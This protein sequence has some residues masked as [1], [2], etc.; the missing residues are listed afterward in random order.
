MNEIIQVLKILRRNP[1]I[2]NERDSFAMTTLH[3]AAKRGLDHI[4]K[5]LLDFGAEV[6]CKDYLGRKPYEVAMRAD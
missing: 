4:A 2:V 1:E 6:H 5:M 3:W